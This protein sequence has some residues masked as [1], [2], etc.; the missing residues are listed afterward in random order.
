MSVEH[1][2]AKDYAPSTST[3]ILDW[4]A[5]GEYFAQ[6]RSLDLMLPD[7]TPRRFQIFEGR[8]VHKN[9]EFRAPEAAWKLMNTLIRVDARVVF[10]E[11]LF[12]DTVAHLA[13]LTTRRYPAWHSDASAASLRHPL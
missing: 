5:S 2:C 4:T 10:S 9:A 3:L 6:V 1:Q 8:E 12:R 11:Q 7:A 13:Q